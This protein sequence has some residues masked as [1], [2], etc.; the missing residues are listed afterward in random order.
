MQ[1]ILLE[2]ITHLG[3]LGAVVKV[4]DGYAR[5]FLIPQGH[6]KRATKA[7]IEA[8]CSPDCVEMEG[9]AVS[10]IAAKNDVPC[11][12]LRAMSDNA[13]EDGHEVLVVKKFSIAEYV[14][15]ATKIVAAM[16]EKL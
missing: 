16:V 2:K 11:V 7:A 10:Q 1:V 14:A 3:E 9:A 13:D 4:K 5:N 15:T 6:A 12:I 8:K